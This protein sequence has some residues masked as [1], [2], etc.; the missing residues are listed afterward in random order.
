MSVGR[1]SEESRPL[2]GLR[3][4]EVRELRVLPYV[5]NMAPCDWALGILIPIIWVHSF[6]C[7]IV[8]LH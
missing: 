7:R 1:L 4:E 8:T 2:K 3:E 6:T 5:R